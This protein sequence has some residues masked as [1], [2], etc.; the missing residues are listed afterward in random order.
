MNNNNTK[1]V[2]RGTSE[3]AAMLD[4]IKR[5][6]AITAKINQ[7]TFDALDEIKVLFSD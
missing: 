1:I 6:M 5:A 3:S 2:H 4:S 7:L